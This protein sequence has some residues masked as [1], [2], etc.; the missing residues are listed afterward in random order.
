MLKV[1]EHVIDLSEHIARGL[2]AEKLWVG[3]EDFA[4]NPHEYV[5]SMQASRFESCPSDDG[6]KRFARELDFGS[7]LVVNDVIE[8]QAPECF[9]TLVSA[10]GPIPE[11][12]LDIS[13]ESEVSGSLKLR[14]C[15][16]ETPVENAGMTSLMHELRKKA[17]LAKD[18]RAVAQIIEA[19][20]V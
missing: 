15:Y 7:S 8:L 18:Q 13:I 17:W 10:S 19:L 14:F 16:Y 5:D 12:R 1:F 2:T 6:R 4:L 20:E 9:T 3:I 11:S